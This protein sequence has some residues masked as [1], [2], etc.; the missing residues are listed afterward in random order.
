MPDKKRRE[1][2]GG[3]ERL[4]RT[5]LESRIVPAPP[6][7][8]IDRIEASFSGSFFEP[9]RHDTYAIGVT[10]SGIQT[11]QYRGEKHYSQPGQIIVLHPDE[12][13]DGAAATDEG[14]L[15]RMLYL[16]PSLVRLAQANSNFGLPFVRQPVIE[17]NRLCSSLCAALGTLDCHLE[18]IAAT[19]IIGE[20]TDGLNRH[21]DQQSSQRQSIAHTRVWRARDFLFENCQRNISSLELEQVSGLDRFVLARQFRSEFG[22]SPH[23]FL[24][25]RRLEHARQLM[26]KGTS[27]VETAATVGFADQSHLSRHFK[28]TFGVTPGKW[29]NA[30]TVS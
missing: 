26:S 15:Y 1:W 12:L 24:I 9:H 27:L 14:L 22:T 10:L 4:C 6:L 7:P 3:L 8:G 13:H 29:V 19:D 18:D 25:M 17:D 11:F 23:R 28:K 16:E 20:V 2:L 5:D 30:L 21:S